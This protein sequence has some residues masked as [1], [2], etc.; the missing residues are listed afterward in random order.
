MVR[1]ITKVCVP[2]LARAPFATDLMLSLARR[3]TSESLVAERSAY[4]HL[5]SLAILDYDALVKTTRMIISFIV[6]EV[7]EYWQIPQLCVF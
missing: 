7:V 2:V 4:L 6:F 5:V 3:R 1:I